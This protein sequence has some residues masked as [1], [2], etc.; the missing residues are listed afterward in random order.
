MFCIKYTVLIGLFVLS[1]FLP[2]PV[3]NIYAQISK[4]SSI[5]YLI[6][7]T[8][9]L[10][11]LFYLYAIKL[12]RMYDDGSTCSGG[13]LIGSTICLE[14]GALILIIFAL[15]QFTYDFCGSTSWLSI[16]TIIILV[17]LP[18]VQL[19]NFNPQNSL[20]TTALVSL[21]ISYTSYAAQ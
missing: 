19:L 20:L 8:I 6:I 12:V 18:L 21:F 7:Q 10:V 13:F 17:I 14:A 15:I 2:A 5:L 9:I 3:L 16:V 1:F 4:I 11:D